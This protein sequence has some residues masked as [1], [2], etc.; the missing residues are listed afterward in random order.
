MPRPSAPLLAVPLLVLA[1]SAC[2]KVEQFRDARRPATPHEAY[3][4]GLHDAGLANTALSQAWIHEAAEAV[5]TPRRVDL[6]FQEEGYIAPEAP[7]AVGYRFSLR[8][9][10]TLNVRLRVNSPEGARVFLDLLRVAEDEADP[11]RPVEADT[12]PEGLVYEPFRDGEFLVRVQ[13]ELL[14]GGEYA[15]ILTLDPALTFPVTGLGMSAIQSGWGAARDG[16]RRSHEGVDIFARRGTPVIASVPGRVSRANVTRLG[17]KVVWLRDDRQNRSLYYAHLDSQA[18]A[19]GDVVRVGDTLGFVG[20]TGNARTTPP[21]LHFGVYYRGEGAV[22]PAPFLRPPPGR[23]AGIDLDRSRY[24]RWVRVRDGE[25]H[26]RAGPSR[27]AG[28]LAE[29]PRHTPARVTG[30][31]AEW[32]RVTLPDGTQGYLAARLTE[33]LTDLEPVVADA[34]AALHAAPHPTSPRTGR[35]ASGE[36]VPVV[37]R[38][39]GYLQVRSRDGGLGWLAAAPDPAAVE[40]APDR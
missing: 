25:V 11:P 32:Y 34:P 40:L 33:D 30:G 21:H 4:Q 28:V 31:S 29:L 26:L 22:N 9:G 20:N 24:G 1:A 37:G 15:V 13:P 16:G 8:R 27:G 12:V 5:R 38:Y 7:E 39:A 18:V 36:T 6:P 19:R 3:L 35:I 17:G 14:R 2:E 23:L 10:Q